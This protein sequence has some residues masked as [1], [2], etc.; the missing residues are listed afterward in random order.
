MFFYSH[1]NKFAFLLLISFFVSSSI[2]AKPKTLKVENKPGIQSL[3]KSVLELEDLAPEQ[4]EKI[5]AILTQ[6]ADKTR[7]LQ[8]KSINLMKNYLDEALQENIKGSAL[9]KRNKELDNN[10]Q[11]LRNYQLETWLL[12]KGQLT[13]KQ[14]TRLRDRQKIVFAL[15]AKSKN[16]NLNSKVKNASASFQK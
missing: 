16:P 7:E 15:L 14:L 6:R 1:K 11:T 3:I 12:V 2:F 13:S 10:Y 9:V 5:E 4:Q 8:D